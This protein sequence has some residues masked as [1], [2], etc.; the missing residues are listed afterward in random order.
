MISLRFEKL[1]KV[2]ALTITNALAMVDESSTE[3]VELTI[4]NLN[5]SE[6]PKII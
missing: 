2:N 1:N 6:V 3:D 4:L 5:Y